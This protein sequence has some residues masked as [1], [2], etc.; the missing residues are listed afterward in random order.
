MDDLGKI[1]AQSVLA[2]IQEI[3]DVSNLDYIIESA[4]PEIREEAV[5]IKEK[6]ASL[7]A[8]LESI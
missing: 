4:E 7:K 3:E 6:M 2:R 8:V 1:L 5:L